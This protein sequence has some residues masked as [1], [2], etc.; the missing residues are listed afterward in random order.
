MISGA[1]LDPSH[2]IS[3]LLAVGS[4]EYSALLTNGTVPGL[5][6]VARKKNAGTVEVPGLKGVAADFPAI[7]GA[8]NRK[9]FGFFLSK[10]RGVWENDD[11]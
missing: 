5:R 10:L 3:S 7:L 9:L 2:A 11:M 6:T 1:S 8:G 4:V